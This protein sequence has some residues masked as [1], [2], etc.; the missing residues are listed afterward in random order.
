[1]ISL[2]RLW[3]K[4]QNMISRG[5]EYWGQLKASSEKEGVQTKIGWLWIVGSFQ[6]FYF[7]CRH[8]KWMT[9]LMLQCHSSASGNLSCSSKKL[10][11]KPHTYS[12]LAIVYFLEIPTWNM[13]FQRNGIIQE[14]GKVLMPGHQVLSLKGY[15]FE[16]S[17][18]TSATQVN[19]I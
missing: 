4:S 17:Y 18:S 2:L 13:L 7:Y 1:M 19:K 12:K 16:V 5:E 8:F 11:K 15:F 14:L 9:S 10:C 3:G 6:I